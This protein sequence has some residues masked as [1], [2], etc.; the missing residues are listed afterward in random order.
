MDDQRQTD[1]QN[2][3]EFLRQYAARV[4]AE[5]FGPRCPDYE[6]QCVCCQRWRALDAL[7]ANPYDE[8]TK[9]ET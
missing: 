9:H 1:W 7:V 5:Y 2:H 6:P 8:A 4:L 3:A